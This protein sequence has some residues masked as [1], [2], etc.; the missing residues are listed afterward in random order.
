MLSLVLADQ[1]V[2]HFVVQMGVDQ[3]NSSFWVLFAHEF[4]QLAI[5]NRREMQNS[6]VFNFK[7]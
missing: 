2:I 7:R 6:V 3:E 4:K 5:A 1:I